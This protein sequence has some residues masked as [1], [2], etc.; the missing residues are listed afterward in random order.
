VHSVVSV[1]KNASADLDTVSLRSLVIVLRT[2]LRVSRR[3][4]FRSSA[5]EHRQCSRWQGKI[6][7]VLSRGDAYPAQRE[8]FQFGAPPPRA[9]TS[10]FRIHLSS[11]ASKDTWHGRSRRNAGCH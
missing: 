9:G 8:D 1:R 10:S 2:S 7:A 5:S 11:G 4:F 3:A 6:H